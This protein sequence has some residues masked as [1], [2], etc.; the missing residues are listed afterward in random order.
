MDDHKSRLWPPSYKPLSQK[1]AKEDLELRIRCTVTG[2]FIAELVDFNDLLVV[3]VVE[4]SFEDALNAL[5][6]KITN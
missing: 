3:Y 1:M 2:S 4:Q 6:G 5:V